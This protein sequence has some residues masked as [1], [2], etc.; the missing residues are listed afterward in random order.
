MASS[1]PARVIGPRWKVCPEVPS[2]VSRPP[3]RMV[4]TEF[5]VV[6]VKELAQPV[7]VIVPPVLM[8]IP[9][10]WPRPEVELFVPPVIVTACETSTV[11]VVEK[12]PRK[13]T[14]PVPPKRK[15]PAPRRVLLEALVTLPL[16][17]DVPKI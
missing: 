7:S 6:P 1:P 4:R 15:L 13:V 3:V 11:P 10:V 2:V 9:A 8:S 17:T 12:S 5:V 14:V 16:R